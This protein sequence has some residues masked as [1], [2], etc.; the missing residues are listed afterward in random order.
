[1]IN[2]ENIMVRKR[3]KAQKGVYIQFHV[4]KVSRIGKSIDTEVQ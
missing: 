4:H 1:M 2:F 3:S